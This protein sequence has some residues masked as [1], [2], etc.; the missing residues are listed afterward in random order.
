MSSAHC[1]VRTPD[2][3]HAAFAIALASHTNLS[4]ETSTCWMP[5][6]YKAVSATTPLAGHMELDNTLPRPSAVRPS[7][8][9]LSPSTLAPAADARSH[10]ALHHHHATKTRGQ[11]AAAIPVSRTALPAHLVGLL[12]A[13]LYSCSLKRPNKIHRLHGVDPVWEDQIKADA[14]GPQIHGTLMC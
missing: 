3:K 7:R 8:C 4:K 13:S 14:D 2:Q 11:P 5:Q 6:H 12:D 1:Q 10:Q 9:R